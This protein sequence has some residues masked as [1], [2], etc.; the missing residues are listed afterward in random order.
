MIPRFSPAIVST[1]LLLLPALAQST[2]S[3]WP[4]WRGPSHN[5]QAAG[6]PPIEWSEERN[7]RW[8]VP[9]PGLGHATPIL[10]GNRIYVQTAVETGGGRHDYR[11]V[12]L[13][14]A[15]G[16]TAWQRTLRTA[17]PNEDGHHGTASYASTSGITDGEHLYAYFGSQGLYCLDLDGNPRWDVDLGNMVTRHS[18][19]EGSSLALHGNTLLV[20]WDHEGDSFIAALDKRTGKELWRRV[21]DEVTSWATPLVI[22]HGGRH[23]VIVPASGKTRSYDL[24]SGALIWECAGLGT[25]VIPMPVYADGIV[26]VAS[27][28]RQPAMQAIRL[29]DAAGDITG[30]A[31]V[32]WSI[33]RD[34]PYVASPLL[35]GGR[36][37]FVKGRNAILSCYD[38]RTGAALF[39]PERL[40][41]MEG[42]VYASLVG[43]GDRIYVSDL[44]GNTVVLRNGPEFEI[45]AANKLNDGFAA[46]PV[47]AG[48]ALYLRG[49]QSL[50]CLATD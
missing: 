41:G 11:L 31:A 39:G 20:N 42:M 40:P 9:V 4:S 35:D 49:H 19:G 1:A 13:D 34:T 36:L 28:H 27:G 8:K 46:S 2:S 44:N 32:L 17:A 22:E 30:T 48:N 16:K 14:R 18:F 25:N 29:A 38:A 50:Y 7:V 33:D 45:L 6:N 5:G 12:A 47:I 43:A 23:Q 24:A 3:D 26:Y 10:W 37:F 15:T 21:R